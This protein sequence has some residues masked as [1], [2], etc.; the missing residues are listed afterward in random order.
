MTP[1][2]KQST[3]NAEIRG[4]ITLFNVGIRKVQDV[5]SVVAGDAHQGK[6]GQDRLPGGGG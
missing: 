3:E 6:K 5:G 1:G 4:Q 2:R